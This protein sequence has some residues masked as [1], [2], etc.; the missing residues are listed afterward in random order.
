[1]MKR[2][3]IPEYKF[4]W[5]YQIHCISVVRILQVVPFR[6]NRNFRTTNEL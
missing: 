1:M 3:D 4:R 2:R 5:T 6:V